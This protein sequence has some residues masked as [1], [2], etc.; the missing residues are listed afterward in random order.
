MIDFTFKL[1]RISRLVIMKIWRRRIWR[2]STISH[3]SS[4]NWSSILNST[5][6]MSMR[7]PVWSVQ[8]FYCEFSIWSIEFETD[9][10]EKPN[11]VIEKSLIFFLKLIL[12]KK[13]QLFHENDRFLIVFLFFLYGYSINGSKAQFL[14]TVLRT[15]T[16]MERIGDWKI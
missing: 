1:Y 9:F 14:F 5:M 8:F 13:I 7:P 15:K 4:A 12:N 3:T 11:F 6:K 10:N 16:H 2:P